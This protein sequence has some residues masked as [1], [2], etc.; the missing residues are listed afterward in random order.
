[1]NDSSPAME[2]GL[3]SA[4]GTVR[5]GVRE[6][7]TPSLENRYLE[8]LEHF[9]RRRDA[10]RLDAA[11]EM[12]RGLVEADIP[13]DRIGELHER[14]LSRL[15]G[16]SATMADIEASSLILA[17]FKELLTAYAMAFR[18]QFEARRQGLQL[19]IQSECIEATNRALED[20]NREL[21]EFAYVVSHDLK[22]P[23][24][25]IENLSLWI[26]EDLADHLQGETRQNMELLRD[27]VGRMSRMIGDLLEYSRAG[28]LRAVPEEVD[29]RALL[30]EIVDLIHPPEGFVVVLAED[31]PRFT[32]ARI[33]FQQVLRNLVVNAV[34]HHDRDDG[35]IAVR[36]EEQGPFYRFTVE[37][38]GPGI[39]PEYHEKVFDK[40]MRL[41]SSDDVE[42]SGMGL[43]LIRK[44]V[45]GAGGTVGLESEPGA[46][47]AFHVTW[48]REW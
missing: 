5:R 31:L 47:C 16:N 8:L 45:N 41:A 1:M 7:E 40:F 22:A 30:E 17:P 32:T 11:M 36:V 14:A 21:E 29:S 26:E 23:L 2:K 43:A 27:R 42:G 39:D 4:P 34:K 24:R 10:G 18:E 19:K 35:R 33:P 13:L 37:D 38:D 48:P 12:G 20:A 44:I 6:R 25:A 46:G 28:R 3:D 9:M 15:A